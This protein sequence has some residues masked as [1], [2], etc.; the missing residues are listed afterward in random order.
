[1]K[2]ESTLPGEITKTS[3]K[4]KA[5]APSSSSDDSEES[6]SS[7]DE[8]AARNGWQAKVSARTSITVSSVV[9]LSPVFMGYLFLHP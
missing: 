7:S 4:P 2:I 9:L 1:M 6:S 3:W 8:D 5:K